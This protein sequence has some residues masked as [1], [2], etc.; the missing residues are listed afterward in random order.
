MRAEHP[1]HD[2]YKQFWASLRSYQGLV[3]AKKEAQTAI[4]DNLHA[5]SRISPKTQFHPLQLKTNPRPCIWS[6]RNPQWRLKKDSLCSPEGYVDRLNPLTYPIL[7]HF[8]RDEFGHLQMETDGFFDVKQYPGY[9]CICK[10]G[11]WDDVYLRRKFSQRVV[12]SN[13]SLSTLMHIRRRR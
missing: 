7:C 8:N 9:L 10:W 3:K 2:Q 1:W 12:L 6:T 11:V 13:R 5:L 4:L